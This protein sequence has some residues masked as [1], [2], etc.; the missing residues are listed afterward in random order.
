M[1]IWNQCRKTAIKGLF[2]NL[3]LRFLD[4]IFLTDVAIYQN[5]LYVVKC[6]ECCLIVAMKIDNFGYK[7]IVFAGHL[8][9]PM[10]LFHVPIPNTQL[11]ACPD[12]G[13]MLIFCG[14]RC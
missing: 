7:E 14:Y 12:T 4:R 8:S 5:Q 9:A 3:S 6:P 11:S 13:F 2:E 1:A 10:K